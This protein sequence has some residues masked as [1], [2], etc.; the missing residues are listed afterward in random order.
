MF[1]LHDVTQCG[2]VRFPDLEKQSLCRIFRTEGSKLL[3]TCPC[4]VYHEDG[5]S[6]FPR[7]TAELTSDDP[8]FN[9]VA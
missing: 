7:N 2:Q 1:Y 4:P 5:G 6:K 8:G 9:F 3:I